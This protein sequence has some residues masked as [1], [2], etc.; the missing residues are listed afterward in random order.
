MIARLGRRK[1]RRL[2]LLLLGVAL[3]LLVLAITLPA[4]SMN[5]HYDE[6]IDGM[7]NQLAIYQR[8]ARHSDQYEAK[9]QQLQ[10]MQNQDRRYLQSESESLATAELQRIVKRVIAANQGEILSTQVMQ[11]GEEEGFMRVSIRIRMKSRLQAM[12]KIFHALES[13]T[14]YLFVENTMVRSRQVARRRLPS[15]KAIEEAM[16]QLDIDFQISGYMRGG[17]S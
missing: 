8:V 9:Y 11:T 4:I 3:L 2:A 14:P 10:H 16:S 13:R 12:V 5:R 15:S 17:Q 7:N 6:Q 1:S